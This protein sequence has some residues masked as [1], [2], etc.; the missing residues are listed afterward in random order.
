ML[1]WIFFSNLNIILSIEQ[2]FQSEVTIP[3]SIA[4]RVDEASNV[5]LHDLSHGEL[6]LRI[7]K[8]VLMEILKEVRVCSRM[9]RRL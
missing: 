5:R 2:C 9:M 7:I 8:V 1:T 4:I 3:Y 6:F